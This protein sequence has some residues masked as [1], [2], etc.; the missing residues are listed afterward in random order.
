MSTDR[1]LHLSSFGRS[2]LT[3]VDGFVTA[4]RAR[5]ALDAARARYPRGYVDVEQDFAGRPYLRF[6][7]PRSDAGSGVTGDLCLLLIDQADQHKRRMH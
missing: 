3:F 1:P 5:L 6:M 2:F 7:V 4:R